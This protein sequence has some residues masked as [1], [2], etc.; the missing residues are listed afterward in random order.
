MSIDADDGEVDL[1]DEQR[2]DSINTEG[3]GTEVS[4]ATVGEHGKSGLLGKRVRIP[5]HV[6]YRAFVSE[7]VVLNL[8]TGRYHGV[9]RT[10]ARMLD[11]LQAADSV[12]QA[13]AQLAREYGQPVSVLE[14]DLCQFCSD[15]SERELIDLVD[16][17]D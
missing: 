13:A 12:E 6:V 11:V 10:G 16:G 1:P 9:N 17:N 5:D 7:T 14:G 2:S 15:L 3:V 4:A 8:R